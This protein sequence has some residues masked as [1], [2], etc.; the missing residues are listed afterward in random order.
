[1]ARAT[2]PKKLKDTK[3][4]LRRAKNNRRREVSISAA[5]YKGDKVQL[6]RE[7]DAYAQIHLGHKRMS[8]SAYVNIKLMLPH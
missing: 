4:I 3:Y 7:A 1:M 8:I 2:V 6:Q 5:A